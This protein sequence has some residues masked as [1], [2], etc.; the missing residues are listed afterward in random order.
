MSFKTTGHELFYLQKGCFLFNTIKVPLASFI[1][2]YVFFSNYR[3]TQ[4]RKRNIHKRALSSHFHLVPE[5]KVMLSDVSAH[6][7]FI[8]ISIVMVLSEIGVQM[9]G[10]SFIRADDAQSTRR[11]IIMALSKILIGQLAYE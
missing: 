8:L 11:P 6:E 10:G 2:W 7:F 4:S 3:A 9:Y 1:S 5:Q